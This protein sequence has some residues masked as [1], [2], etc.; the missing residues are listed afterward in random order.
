MRLVALE[1]S[2]AGLMA[3]ANEPRGLIPLDG[4]GRESPG[5]SLP[6]KKGLLVGREAEGRAHLYPRQFNSRFWD[7]L[8]TEPLK[9]AVPH[10][11]NHAEMASLHMA[12]IW[13]RIKDYGDGL[14]IAVPGFYERTHLGLLL[15]IA[16]ELSIPVQGIVALSVAAALKP[17]PEHLLLHLDIHLHRLELTFLEQD[18]DQLRQREAITI[19]ERGLFFLH[20]EWVQAMADVFVHTTRYDPL[21]QA[22]SEQELYDRL[23]EITAVL[24]TQDSMI[25]EM[26]EGVQS[27][28]ARLTREL[29][30]QRADPLVQDIRGMIQEMGQ[31]H[32]EGR[33]G[34][35]LQ[36]T[37]RI[38]RVPGL[39]KVLAGMADGP[40]MELEPG[41]GAMGAL[42]LWEQSPRRPG[43]GGLSLTAGRPWLSEQ[44][45]PGP[46]LKVE[47]RG[48]GI[49]PPGGPFPTHVLYGD[50]AYPITEEPLL[51]GA[52]GT[53][54]GLETGGLHD[55]AGDR[56][57]AAKSHCSIRR[58]GEE[59]ILENHS[60]SGTYVDG[61][62]I[63]DKA[64]LKIGQTVHMGSD[65]DAIRLIVCV[66]THAT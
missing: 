52:G 15:G 26:K 48:A 66:N 30:M 9:Q 63:S 42:A 23:P 31:R 44:G 18:G 59:V 27:Y 49:I 51:F 36:V 62:L 29:L 17:C 47:V 32:G 57:G 65:R 64:V 19:G 10:A 55:L 16:R 58:K 37:H 53:D 45:R 2:D 24:R 13:Q 35:A 4:V 34:I 33:Q 50:S 41:A 3:A 38:T 39:M 28:R 25:L 40:V 61:Y 7:R 1:L 60:P 5:Y 11:P 8:D 12:F 6:T 20:R 54:W 14:L 21:H 43:Q 46:Q 56:E 22:A